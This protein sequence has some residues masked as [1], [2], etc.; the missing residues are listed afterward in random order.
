MPLVDD[1]HILSVRSTTSNVN[2][3]GGFNLAPFPG[4]GTGRSTANPTAPLK[5]TVQFVKA[6]STVRCPTQRADETPQ[7][8]TRKRRSRNQLTPPSASQPLFSAGLQE[9]G[10]QGPGVGAQW[11][12]ISSR[13]GRVGMA[14]PFLLGNARV[15][16]RLR[17]GLDFSESGW[18]G[19][20]CRG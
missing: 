2:N 17:R 16:S 10:Q 6:H 8:R 13:R 19:C 1:Y 5:S 3:Q 4:S 14:R 15:C 20:G 11:S 18:A 12:V 9:S 7:I